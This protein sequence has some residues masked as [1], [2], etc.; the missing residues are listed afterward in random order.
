MDEENRDNIIGEYNFPIGIFYIGERKDPK[1]PSNKS[2]FGRL[3]KDSLNN[4]FF[5]GDF[6]DEIQTQLNQYLTKEKNNLLIQASD[7]EG[8]ALRIKENGLE[9][10]SQYYQNLK[11]HTPELNSEENK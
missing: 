6:I 2:F 5:Y 9:K 11:N 1:H 3:E 4:I 7:L 8:L 10:T